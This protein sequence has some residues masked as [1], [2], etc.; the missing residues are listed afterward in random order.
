MNEDYDK[1]K[2]KIV[3]IEVARHWQSDGMTV[4]TMTYELSATGQH[5][6]CYNCGG[7]GHMSREF[8]SEKMGE[9][10]GK[11]FGKG[12]T[13]FGKGGKEY[14]KG[15]EDSGKGYQD[16]CFNCGKV[17]HK[18][19]ECRSRSVGVVD[20]ENNGNV[21]GEVQAGAVEMGTSWNI[22]G[23]GINKVRWRLTMTQKRR[24]SRWWIQVA[25]AI[26]SQSLFV[27]CASLLRRRIMPRKGWS[28]VEVPNGWLQIMWPLA[29]VQSKLVQ[30]PSPKVGQRP[31]AVH[32]QRTESHKRQRRS[33]A[34]VRA[35]ATMKIGPSEQ[36]LPVWHWTTPRRGPV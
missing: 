1:S 10:K 35:L 8:P 19:W 34:E 9:E 33:P 29:K 32:P 31:P 25:L 13:D 14:G 2:Q 36:Q 4:T 23:V 7:W 12:G 5:T 30:K 22:G 16:A 28:A 18:A 24:R 15:G 26:L 21:E 3:W 20:E 27:F 17:G 6:Q 11:D